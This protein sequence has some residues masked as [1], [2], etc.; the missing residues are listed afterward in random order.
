MQTPGDENEPSVFRKLQVAP[1]QVTFHCSSD[2]RGDEE[3]EPGH[4]PKDGHSM[5]EDEIL[6][7]S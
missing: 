4:I 1:W 7:F 5:P 2:G 3:D 6:F